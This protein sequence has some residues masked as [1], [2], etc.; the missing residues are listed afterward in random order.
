[1]LDTH[2]TLDPVHAAIAAYLAGDLATVQAIYA[3]LAECL[4]AML[5]DVAVDGSDET[6]TGV[7]SR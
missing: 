5:S 4:D 3:P 6:L 1:M 2:P 7:A